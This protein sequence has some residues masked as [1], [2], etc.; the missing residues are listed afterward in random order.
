MSVLVVR[1]GVGR[2]TLCASIP[3]LFFTFLASLSLALMCCDLG[4]SIMIILDWS[5]RSLRMGHD[6]SMY[7]EFKYLECVLDESGTDGAVSY[8]GG[9]L[10]ES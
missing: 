6:W 3:F 1:D 9:E 2:L 7:Q 10:E 8:E 4:I 5:E